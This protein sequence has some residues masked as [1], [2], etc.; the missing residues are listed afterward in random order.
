VVSTDEGDATGTSDAHGNFV[1]HG[2]TPG[3]LHV[4]AA[5][6]KAGEGTSAQVRARGRET[7]SSLRI[8]LSGRYT[9]GAQDE[10][11]AAVSAPEQAGETVIDPNARSKQ[12]MSISVRRTRIND[13]ELG[14]HGSEIVF[15]EVARGGGAE[16][17][18][19]HAGDVLV[20]IDGE[21]V[22]SSAQARGMLRDPPGHFA[23]LRL[24]RNKAQI[25]IRYKR[26]AL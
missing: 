20:A 23:N 6:R 16:R 5:H 21:P 9:P 24:S 8:V 13:F 3:A 15:S 1:L 17:A 25:R 2:V 19:V 11:S 18:G 22:L 12:P 10:P 4:L 26:P 7:L 14:Q